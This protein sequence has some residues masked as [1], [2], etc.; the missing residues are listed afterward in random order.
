MRRQPPRL[1]GFP[2]AALAVGLMLSVR[3]IAGTIAIS[4]PSTDHVTATD[5]GTTGGRFTILSCPGTNESC[6]FAILGPANAVSSS[7]LS[8]N[9]NTNIFENASLTTLSDTLGLTGCSL[10]QLGSC[11]QFESDREVPPSPLGPGAASLVE[12]PTMFQTALILAYQ[13]SNGAQ[14]GT[15]DTIT[16]QSDA[17]VPEPSTTAVGL[18][19]L[20]LIGAFI[21]RRPSASRRR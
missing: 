10:G 19:G 8:G 3:A 12:D 9:F 2:G 14:L 6:T 20:S 1:R 13:D 5:N 18:T 15:T 21:L 4:D 7:L 16:F 17:D 11:W